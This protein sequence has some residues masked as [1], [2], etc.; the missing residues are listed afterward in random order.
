MSDIETRLTELV[1]GV[2]SAFEP[3]QGPAV[4]ALAERIAG[5]RYRGWAEQVGDPETR[6]LLIA[7]AEREA[8]IAARVEAV[9]PGASEVQAGVQASHPDLAQRYAALFEGL[10]LEEQFAQQARA[11]RLGAATWRSVAAASASEQAKVFHECAKLEEASAEVLE[12][13]VA[14]GRD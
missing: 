7:C 9:V 12:A 8:E 14:A 1:G 6:V 5:E 3:E 13:L 4:I 11:E 10:P 2:L